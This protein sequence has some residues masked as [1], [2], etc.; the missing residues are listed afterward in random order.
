[1]AHVREFLQF[2][3]AHTT[4]SVSS[5]LFLDINISHVFCT[6]FPFPERLLR[7]R[8]DGASRGYLTIQESIIPAADTCVGSATQRRPGLHT[9]GGYLLKGGQVAAVF[10]GKS[11]YNEVPHWEKEKERARAGGREAGQWD[12][13]NTRM[14]AFAGE[15]VEPFLKRGI[16][17]ASTVANTTQVFPSKPKI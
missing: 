7:R 14:H 3:C 10:N 15:Y 16:F 2:D 13:R 11:W 6:V 1:L 8:L 5:S 12:G 4:L 17:M 9:Q